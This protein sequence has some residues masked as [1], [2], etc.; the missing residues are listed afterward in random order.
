MNV[1][2]KISGSSA[3][4]GID[5]HDTVTFGGLGFGAG[6]AGASEGEAFGLG[7]GDGVGDGIAGDTLASEEGGDEML[8]LV[9]PGL[10]QADKTVAIA[11]AMPSR[12]RFMYQQR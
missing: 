3:A 4:T 1:P 10:P 8:W 12:I 6:D 7:L 11:I 9:G 2:V 5:E